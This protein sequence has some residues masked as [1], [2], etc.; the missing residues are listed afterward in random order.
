MHVVGYRSLYRTVLRG[1]NR[2]YE[3]PPLVHH[4]V[5]YNCSAR[6]PQ[7]GKG[8]FRCESWQEAC[9]GPL[10]A[11]GSGERGAWL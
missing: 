4:L 7:L 8:P 5:T 2:S 6:P 9:Q 1:S 3:G 11:S 10:L